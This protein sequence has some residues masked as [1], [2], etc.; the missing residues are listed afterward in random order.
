MGDGTPFGRYRLL[1]LLGRGGMGEVWRA[2]DT[3]TERVVALKVLPA[4]YAGDAVFQERFRREARSAAGLDEPHVVPIHDFGEIDG[5]LYVTMRLIQGRDLQSVLSE[6]RIDALRAVGIVDQVASALQA[7]HRVNLVHRDVKPSNILVCEDDFAYL[8]D[9]GIAR[10]AGQSGLTSA[11]SVI[12]TWAY[13]AP[14]RITTGHS[15]TRADVYALACVLYECLTGRQPFGSD[16]LEQQIGGHLTSPPPRPSERH[17][18]VPAGLDTVIARGMA[19]NPD[20]R[21]TTTRELAQAARAAVAGPATRPNPQI[22][23]TPTFAAPFANPYPYPQSGGVANYPVPPP[24]GPSPFGPT[25]YRPMPY[26]PTGPAPPGPP[27]P[28]PRPS[29]K[30]RVIAL[31][32]LGALAVVVAVVAAIALSN[33]GEDGPSPLGRSPG[34]TPSAPASTGPLTGGFTVALGPKTRAN[35]T[36]VSNDP[37][38]TP[39][40]EPWRLRSACGA[41]GCVATASTGGRYPAKDLVFDKVGD[42]WLAVANSRRKCANR[43]DDEAWNV[44]VLQQQADG[45]MS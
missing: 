26:V 7:A 19:K 25:Q 10:A 41:N 15:D 5:R 13:M 21:Y 18:D 37:D 16:S 22:P 44:I 17:P 40:S 45:S 9:F 34:A 39:Y 32:S 11:S 31:S 28:G 6:G 43:D 38:A 30:G 14:E 24:S 35:G 3:V 29:R 8:I 1:D 23:Q 27:P 4:Q 33:S 20:E 12:G 42:R 36:P 2:F